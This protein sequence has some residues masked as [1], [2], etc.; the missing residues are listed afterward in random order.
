MAATP[1]VTATQFTHEAWTSRT[2]FLMAAMG[3]AVGL[4]NIWRF[5]YVAGVNGGGGFVLL[6]LGFVFLLGLPIMIGE[7]VIG[8]RGHQSAITSMSILVARGNRSPF[9]KLIGWLSVIVPFVGLTYYS[10]VAAWSL[11]YLSLAVTGA[12]SDFTGTTAQDNFEQQIAQPI[13]QTLLHG[14]FIALTVAVVARGLHSGIE[15][16]AKLLMPALF[17]ILIGLVVYNGFTA[18]FGRAFNFLFRP[19]FSQITTQAVL[20]ALGQALFS[21][22]IGV[23]VMMTYS[24]YLPEKFSLPESAAIICVGDTSVALLAGLAIFPIVFA[25]GLD[26][27]EGPGLIFVSLPVA[28]GSMPGG[29]I[30]GSLF[31]LLLFFAAYTTSIGML[32]PLV[33]WLEERP[34][35]KRAPMAIGSGVIAW[36]LG[37]ASVLSFSILRGWHPLDFL[38]VFV[39]KTFFD[40]LDFTIANVLLPINALLIALFAGW[41]LSRAVAHEELGI[42]DGVLFG[43]WRFAV[44]FLVPVALVLIIIDLWR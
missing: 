39:G 10:V 20:M 35:A 21:L 41:S 28:F 25:S 19:D 33:S 17:A 18:D 37:F 9:W 22:A 7:M 27:S 43:Y 13:R 44:R 16:M 34:G 3:A 38:D 23:G 12:F 40:V 5:P 32:E 29:Q 24:A 4:G 14:A 8:R 15:R 26:A 42:G 6:Y 11:D 30:I 2:A 31:F 36:I 1:S